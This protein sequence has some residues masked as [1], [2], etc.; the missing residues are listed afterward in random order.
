VSE[1][2][3]EIVIFVF[4]ESVNKLC[5]LIGLIANFDCLVVLL[6]RVIIRSRRQ[7]LC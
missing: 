6:M 4:A 1:S 5:S 3:L 7:L 2:S